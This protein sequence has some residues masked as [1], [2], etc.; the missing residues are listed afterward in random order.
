VS[1]DADRL[2]D[3]IQADL[4][5][6]LP[7]AGRA[8]LARLLLS[9]PAARRL[10]EEF[11]Q[12]DRLLRDI[13]SAEP[14][15]GLREAILAGPASSTQAG[16]PR[17]QSDWP[18]Y[19]IAATILGGLLIVGLAYLVR[20]G[21]APAK[22]LQGS[23]GVAP[24]NAVS[25]RAEGVEV[26]ASLVRSGTTQR[27]ELHTSTTVPCEVIARIDPG[28]TSYIGKTGEARLSVGDGR[29]QVLPALGDHSVVLQFSGASPIHLEL[30]A[31]GRLLG[32]GRLESAP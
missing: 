4:D 25:L 20:D 19:R 1:H 9:D 2:Q 22:E 7:A 6:E 10:H 31:A 3:L 32:E 5:G 30:R 29:V 21:D 14:P 28:T 23:L 24:R 11:R 26:G 15:A 8:E 13:G 18:A 16:E 17:R 12:T 27:L